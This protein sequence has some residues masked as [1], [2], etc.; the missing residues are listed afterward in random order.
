MRTSISLCLLSI[1]L[2]TVMIG[3]NKDDNPYSPDHCKL[4]T[5]RFPDSSPITPPGFDTLVYENNRLIYWNNLYSDITDSLERIRIKN[6]LIYHDNVVDIYMSMSYQNWTEYLIGS[7]EF[8]DSLLSNIKGSD[9]E[10]NYSYHYNGKQLSYVLNHWTDNDKPDSS[11][12]IYDVK[13]DNIS[14]LVVYT[15]DYVLHQYIVAGRSDFIFDNWIN[16]YRNSFYFLSQNAGGYEFS[17]AYFDKNNILS[18]TDEW[19]YEIKYLYKYKNGLVVERTPVW[20]SD[21]SATLRYSY[22]CD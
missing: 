13:G 1:F 16:P 10:L 8:Q 3:C 12:M 17:L 4:N 21:T 18:I 6:W 22:L 14:K 20:G 19:G 2:G 7:C 9:G 15:Y 5:V 11:V